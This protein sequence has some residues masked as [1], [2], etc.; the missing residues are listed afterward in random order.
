MKGRNLEDAIL[1]LRSSASIMEYDRALLTG[2]NTID[3]QALWE[4]YKVTGL[5]IALDNPTRMIEQL[6]DLIKK[7]QIIISSRIKSDAIPPTIESVFYLGA[8]LEEIVQSAK[9]SLSLDFCFYFLS[10]F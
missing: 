5:D 4:T 7:I 8:T 6:N 1:S 2:L 9:N 3:T 10:L